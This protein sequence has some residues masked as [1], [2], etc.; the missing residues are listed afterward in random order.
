MQA[1]KHHGF[2]DDLGLASFY[3]EPEGESCLVPAAIKSVW[4][5]VPSHH[6]GTWEIA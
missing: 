1:S 3:M 2:P 5:D 4:D 6:C